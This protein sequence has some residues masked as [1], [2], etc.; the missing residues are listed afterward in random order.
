MR[1]PRE[2]AT[3]AAFVL[4]RRKQASSGARGCSGSL[5]DAPPRHVRRHAIKDTG[6]RIR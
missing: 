1:R 5:D 3:G 2:I 4:T 6:E